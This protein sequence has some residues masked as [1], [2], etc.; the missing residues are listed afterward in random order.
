MTLHHFMV[1]GIKLRMFLTWL[2]LG[3]FL[4][5]LAPVTPALAEAPAGP[6]VLLEKPQE[7][8]KPEEKKEA[9]PTTAGC[10]MTDSTI[11]IDTGHVSLSAMWPCPST[12]GPSTK[13]GGR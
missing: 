10:I 2:F 12:P 13:A 9:A 6:Q 11:P 1:K 7:A 5:G 4:V 8:A 3:C